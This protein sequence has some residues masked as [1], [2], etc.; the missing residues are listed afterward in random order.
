LKNEKK[1]RRPHGLESKIRLLFSFSFKGIAFRDMVCANGQ[2]A[3]ML[4][5]KPGLGL[6]QDSLW[7]SQAESFAGWP[8]VAMLLAS[9][10]SL[11]LA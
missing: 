9:F 7:I 6:H 10:V 8:L 3:A 2:Q 1:Y 11:Y 4:R 5:E